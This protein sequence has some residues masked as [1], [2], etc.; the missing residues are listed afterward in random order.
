MR[1]IDEIDFSADNG[2]YLKKRLFF[3]F[4]Y[5]I[6]IM[7]I[8]TMILIAA[9]FNKHD[10]VGTNMLYYLSPLALIVPIGAW[11][12]PK[13]VHRSLKIGP[14]G[15]HLFE[16]ST[17]VQIDWSDIKRVELIR[18]GYPTH[19]SLEIF[20]LT[21]RV[22]VQVSRKSQIT[23]WDSNIS[24]FEEF[25]VPAGGIARTIQEGVDDWNMCNG[26][27]GAPE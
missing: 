5:I 23:G 24:I 4:L 18:P 21:P 2:S 7:A 3:R 19:G 6:A 15:I 16:A 10:S 11:L 25:G 17:V 14:T 1:P 9:Y 26:L 8:A 20:S 27:S 13:P 12:M 22:Y